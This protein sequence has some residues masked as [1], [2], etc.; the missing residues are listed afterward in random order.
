MHCA[1]HPLSAFVSR[2]LVHHP[3]VEA[4]WSLGHA[5]GAGVAV[6]GPHELLLIADEPTLLSLRRS[7][8]S[9]DVEILVVLDGDRFES[10]WGARRLSGSLARWAW[11]RVSPG[12][13]YYD[14]SKWDDGAHTGAVVRVRRK[15]L[16]I[17]QRATALVGSKALA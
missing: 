16:L 9:L 5:E 12:L 3:D 1:P 15:A 11:R 7:P 13:A 10:A 14:E 2:L 8:P 6:H 4:A 17:W